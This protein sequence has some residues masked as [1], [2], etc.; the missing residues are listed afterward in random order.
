MKAV[1]VKHFPARFWQW[2]YFSKTQAEDRQCAT[3]YETHDKFV[4]PSLI[5]SNTHPNNWL[6]FYATL[7]ENFV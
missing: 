5:K 4:Y 6:I 7:D 2:V 3:S 1:Q